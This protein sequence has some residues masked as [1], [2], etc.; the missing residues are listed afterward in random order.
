MPYFCFYLKLDQ[1]QTKLGRCIPECLLVACPWKAAITLGAV[2]LLVAGC[3]PPLEAQH[4]SNP[5]D[6]LETWR[7][8]QPESF[9]NDNRL[10]TQRTHS[11]DLRAPF[12]TEIYDDIPALPGSAL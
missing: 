10:L 12:T 3:V 1:I 4:A 8:F 9:Q 2:I 7:Y 11:L 5:K 6:S